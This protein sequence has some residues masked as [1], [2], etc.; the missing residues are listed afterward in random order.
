[1]TGTSIK[2]DHSNQVLVPVSS[3][4][5][6]DQLTGLYTISSNHTALL[7][8]IRTGKIFGDKIEVLSGLA[9]NEKYIVSADGNLYNGAPV[10]EK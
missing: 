5:N 3:L 1:V 9:A 2:D 10:K 4:V 8:W 7:R 6:K